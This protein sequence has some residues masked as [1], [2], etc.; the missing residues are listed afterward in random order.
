MTKSD[1]QD[2]GDLLSILLVDELF[3]DNEEMIID[4]CITFFT[5]GS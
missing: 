5:A 4:E 3:K 1:Y 2:K